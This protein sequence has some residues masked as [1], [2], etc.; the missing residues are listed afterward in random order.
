LANLTVTPDLW[1][2]R[3]K[4]AHEMATDLS[5]PEARR[6]MLDIAASYEIVAQRA[7]TRRSDLI[8]AV[9]IVENDVKNDDR[10]REAA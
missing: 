10:E 3:A 1:L 8:D 4:E 7:R 5:D 2:Q 6:A 9:H